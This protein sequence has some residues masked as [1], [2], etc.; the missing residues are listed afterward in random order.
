MFGFMFMFVCMC[1][2]GLVNSSMVPVCLASFFCLLSSLS[3]NKPPHI[4][5]AGHKDKKYEKVQTIC[6][7]L[8][9]RNHETSKK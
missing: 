7:P 5:T 4:C 2:Y 9:D 6:G 3:V 8:L 1:L